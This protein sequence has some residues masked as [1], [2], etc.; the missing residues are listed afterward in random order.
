MSMEK[1]RF[2][3]VHLSVHNHGSLFK[4]INVLQCKFFNLKKRV[5]NVCNL[6]LSHDKYITH[7]NIFHDLT[8]M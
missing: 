6:C 1:D 7:Y 2:A 5:A 8:Q 3:N 4:G